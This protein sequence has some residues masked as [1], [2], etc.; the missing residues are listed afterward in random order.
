M[1]YFFFAYLL[2]I[3]LVVG[4]AGFRGDKFTHTPIEIFNDMDQQAKVKA[5]ASNAFFADGVGSRKPVTA[6]VPMGLKVPTAT[7]AS[8][9][10]AAYGFSHGSDYYNTGKIGEFWGD[11]Y[12]E[13]VIVDA[14][15]IR[16]GKERYDI[17]CAV[18]HGKAG[19]GKGVASHYGVPN[20]ANFTTPSFTDSKAPD[21]RANGNMFDTISH[22]RGMMGSYG[23]NIPLKER[24]AIIA[25]I[26][27]M[28]LSRTAPLSDSSIKAAWTSLAP[29]A[30]AGA[31]APAAATPA[32]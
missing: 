11:G 20:I 14:A 8:G 10:F 25:W 24:W 17:N 6:T 16:L 31:P 29:P 9:S 12:P 21:Y 4:F 7:A 27:T 30:P 18:C 22:G 26:R 3:V 1:R 15:F 28:E 23:A 19:D 32:K 2:A 5:Q 13:Q